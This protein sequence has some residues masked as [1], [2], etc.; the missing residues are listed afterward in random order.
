MLL[1]LLLGCF[2]APPD[3]G[4]QKLLMSQ[5]IWYFLIAQENFY[6]TLPVASIPSAIFLVLYFK[7]PMGNVLQLSKQWKQCSVFPCGYGL[8]HAMEIRAMDLSRQSALG[9]SSSASSCSIVS[10]AYFTV[11]L[12]SLSSLMENTH[13]LCTAGFQNG[14]QP[15]VPF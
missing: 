15:T 14:L 10:F 3:T 7:V 1:H 13:F 12:S 8:F 5:S 11:S 9:T 4:E 2:T 6:S